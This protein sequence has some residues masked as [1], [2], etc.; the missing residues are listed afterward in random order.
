MDVTNALNDNFEAVGLN[1]NYLLYN[2]GSMIIGI[3]TMPVIIFVI[4]LLKI[5][6]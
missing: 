1:S 5:F 4:L 6:R 3:L 2:L